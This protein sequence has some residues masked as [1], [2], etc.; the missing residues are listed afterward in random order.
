MTLTPLSR[1]FSAWACPCDPNPTIATVFPLTNSAARDHPDP[2]VERLVHTSRC[3]SNSFP[4]E[5][6][7]MQNQKKFKIQKLEERIAP[8]ITQTNGGG[9][10]P[11]GQANGIPSTNP[12]GKEP[13]GQNK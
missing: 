10:E 13:A 8:A 12:A 11:N 2:Q 1:R 4:L 6:G 9:H 7:I 5:G 3:I